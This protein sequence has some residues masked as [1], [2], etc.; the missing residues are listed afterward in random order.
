[1]RAVGSKIWEWIKSLI[2][3]ACCVFFIKYFVIQNFKVPT[4]SMEKTILVGDF[5]FANKFIYGVKLPRIEKRFLKIREPRRGDV[6][7]FRYP[8]EPRKAYIKRCIG[9]PGDTIEIRNKVVYVNGAPLVENYVTHRDRTVY[10]ALESSGGNAHYQ[11]L[12][13]D[14]GFA[15]AGGRVRDSFGPIEVP[16]SSY[17]MLGD[18]RDNSLDSRFW[19]PVQE[20]LILGK[21]LFLYWSWDSTVPLYRIWE[22]VRWKR[23]G[24]PVR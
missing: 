11:K 24:S 3:A 14:R 16:E 7:V 20:E 21:A 23:I 18:N 15:R 5:L 1:L 22:K 10:P 12:W 8:L 13:Q 9:T 19:G 4:G 2:V 17:F 6:V